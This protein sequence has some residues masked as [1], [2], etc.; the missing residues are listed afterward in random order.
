MPPKLAPPSNPAVNGLNS[1]SKVGSLAPGRREKR[2]TRVEVPEPVAARK[3]DPL[4]T[5]TEATRTPLVSVESKAKNV[6][7]SSKLNSELAMSME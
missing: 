1:S 3:S 4:L 2:L 7:N 5:A 6:V